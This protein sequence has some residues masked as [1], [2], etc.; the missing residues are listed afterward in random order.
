MT[1]TKLT[2]NGSGASAETVEPE[3][4]Y[5]E[6]PV[7]HVRLNGLPIPLATFQAALLA[8]HQLQGGFDVQRLVLSTY[9]N[10]GRA[11][12]TYL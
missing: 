2:A 3:K 12:N 9:Q 7:T 4:N 11:G 8:L 10:G 5:V 6:P 1:R